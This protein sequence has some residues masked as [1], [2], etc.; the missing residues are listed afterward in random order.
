VVDS[1]FTL[2]QLRAQL[3]EWER[4]YNT[5]RPHLALGYLTPLERL[6]QH[7]KRDGR[8][9]SLAAPSPQYGQP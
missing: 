1:D 6:S 9:I 8:A 5:V 4:T 2:A 3:L 7:G